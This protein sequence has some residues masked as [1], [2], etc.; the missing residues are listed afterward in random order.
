MSPSSMTSSAP[1]FMPDRFR[2]APRQ[3]DVEEIE[4]LVRLTR[5]F[6]DA[7]VALAR[8]L[9]EENLAKGAEASGYHFL[10]A[11]GASGL[12]GY[13]CFGHIPGTA[14]RWELYWIAVDPGAHRSGLGRRLQTAS[15]VAV[16]A[17]G[18]V[19]LIAETSTR[20]DYAPARRFYLAQGYRLLA[21]IPDWHDDGDGL[22]IFGKRL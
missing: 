1:H 8:E 12:E 9:V 2:S 22:A 16:K 13:T 14:G 18:G 19:L 7:E 5:V 6:N 11:D 20:L 15:E 17:L 10:F 4:R 21:E 3:A